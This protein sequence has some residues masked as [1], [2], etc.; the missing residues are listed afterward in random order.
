M[1]VD[2]PAQASGAQR[3]P[4]PAPLSGRRPALTIG[5][6]VGPPL[7]W[8]WRVAVLDPPWDPLPELEAGISSSRQAEAAKGGGA[9]VAVPSASGSVTEVGVLPSSGGVS[10]PASKASK[11]YKRIPAAFEP[12]V[13]LRADDFSV[14]PPAFPPRRGKVL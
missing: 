3:A 9:V 4:H 7:P 12:F 10:T 8:S 6:P 11:L 13:H 1:G 14:P 2:R 5:Q